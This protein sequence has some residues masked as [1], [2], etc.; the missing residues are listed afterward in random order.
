MLPAFDPAGAEP[1]PFGC[2]EAVVV[3]GWAEGFFDYWFWHLVSGWLVREVEGVFHGELVQG[4]EPFRGAFHVGFA[5]PVMRAEHSIDAVVDAALE[6]AGRSVGVV[7]E[8]GEH[9]LV[10][11]ELVE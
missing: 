3:E 7:F 9:V 1:E 5:H 6:S 4:E 10:T 8:V 11:S 2:V